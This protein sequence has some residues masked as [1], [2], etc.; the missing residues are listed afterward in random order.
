LKTFEGEPEWKYPREPEAIRSWRPGRFFRLEP[1]GEDWKEMFKDGI[2]PDIDIDMK[3]FFKEVRTYHY[4]NGEDYIVTIEGNPHD[5]D[6]TVTVRVG[7]DEYTTTAY[8]IDKLPEKYREGAEDAIENAIRRRW[9]RK[10]DLKPTPRSIPTQ[11]G[12]K[13][14]FEKLRPRNY[15]S[16]PL[17]RGEEMFE[18]LQEQMRQLRE[19]LEELEQR[20]RERWEKLEQRYEQMF[21]RP[22]GER[23]HD[24][25]KEPEQRDRPEPD[26]GRSA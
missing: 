10:F 11:P 12:W 22:S 4:S 25:S 1:G 5:E 23:D 6:S 20:N 8:E 15:P 7:V 21:N 26:D 18:K 13:D 16:Q 2:P 24:E 3:R 9:I 14:Y 19:H 17:A